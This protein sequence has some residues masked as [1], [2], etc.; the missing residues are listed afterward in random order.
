L[1]EKTMPVMKNIGG[2]DFASY[3]GVVMI[4]YRR[5]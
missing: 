3:K 4:A 5:F 1:S 2:N